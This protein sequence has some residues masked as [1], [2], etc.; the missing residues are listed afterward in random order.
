MTWLRIIKNLKNF[1]IIAFFL[2]YIGKRF[3]LYEN[4]YLSDSFSLYDLST[5]CVLIFIFL[6]LKESRIELKQKDERIKEL[7]AQLKQ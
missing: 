1:F 7:E 2:L 6:Y 4:Y 3:H 5:L